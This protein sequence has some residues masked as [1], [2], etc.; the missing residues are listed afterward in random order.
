[1]NIDIHCAFLFSAPTPARLTREH[2]DKTSS[3][4][5]A[6]KMLAVGDIIQ[7]HFKLLAKFAV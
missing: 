7:Y 2:V 4:L 5:T 3:Q 6:H 1:M